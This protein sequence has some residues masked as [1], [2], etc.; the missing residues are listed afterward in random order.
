MPYCIFCDTQLGPD[1]TEEHI[2]HD[3]LG[4]RETTSEVLCSRH[5]NLFGGTIDDAFAEPLLPIRNLMQFRS[6]SG[7]PPPMLR[8]LQA[9]DDLINVLASGEI[10]LANPPIKF[11]DAAD[12][13]SGAKITA[14]EPTVVKKLLANIATR[15]NL[16]VE[17]VEKQIKTGGITLMERRPGPVNFKVGVGGPDPLRSMLKSCLV[18]LARNVGNDIVKGDNFR[19]AREFV[20]RG[21]E[22]FQKTYI[23][24]DTRDLPG[25]LQLR[26]RFSPFFNMIYIRSNGDGRAIGHFTIYNMIGWRFVLCE[27]GGPQHCRFALANNPTNP[28]IRTRDATEL[29]DIPYDWLDAESEAQYDRMRERLTEMQTEYSQ[30]AT[31]SEFGRIVD[32]TIAKCSLKSGDDL[33]NEFIGRLTDRAARFVMGLPY[34][35]AL[36]P[37]EL[38]NLLTGKPPR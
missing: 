24:L 12:G 20:L 18:L 7:G 2:L 31:S 13:N 10:Q 28:A 38:N 35:E 23:R 37:D 32:D 36:S 33:S 5:N 30:R 6:G 11:N 8:G 19:D 9:G 25:A 14:A 27:H 1:T 16:S 21:D 3:C 34:E 29:P 4:G 17:E 15:L 26:E 22:Q